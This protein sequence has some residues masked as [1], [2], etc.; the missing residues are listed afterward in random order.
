MNIEV[1]IYEDIDEEEEDDYHILS[2]LVD[3]N[4]N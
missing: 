4:N 1:N 2:D 3:Y